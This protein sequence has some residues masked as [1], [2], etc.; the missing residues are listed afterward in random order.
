MKNKKSL[1]RLFVEWFSWTK[2]GVILTAT[3]PFVV[4]FLPSILNK[5]SELEI[6]KENIKRYTMT[7]DSA[8]HADVSEHIYSSDIYY[9]E[10]IK[11]LIT[12]ITPDFDVSYLKDKDIDAFNNYVSSLKVQQIYYFTELCEYI[13]ANVYEIFGVYS[14]D[15]DSLRVNKNRIYSKNEHMFFEYEDAVEK[16]YKAYKK[17]IDTIDNYLIDGNTNAVIKEIKLWEKDVNYF[18]FDEIMLEYCVN[19]LVI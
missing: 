14:Y 13:D 18:R 5:K 16:K 1:Y 19:E 2:V 6:K 8:F 4:F 9:A 7:I 3:I 12:L 10:R 17:H 15:I 11:E